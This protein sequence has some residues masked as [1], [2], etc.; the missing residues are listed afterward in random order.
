MY[1]GDLDIPSPSIDGISLES[2][3][4][5]V[6]LLREIAMKAIKIHP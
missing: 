4:A 5:I 3:V 2:Q 1:S 6:T